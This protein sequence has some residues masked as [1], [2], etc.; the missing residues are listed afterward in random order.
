M[1]QPPRRSRRWTRRCEPSARGEC[2]PAL[3][4][5]S[6]TSRVGLVPGTRPAASSGV[7]QN[8]FRAGRHGVPNR[9]GL[10][11][12][13]P[14]AVGKPV[15]LSR[16]AALRFLPPALH[17]PALLEPPERRV[18]RPL[19]EIEEPVRPFAQF[20]ED[21]EAVLLLLREEGEQAQL[22]R[23][24]LQLRGPL[25]RDFG[26]PGRL[27]SGPRYIGFRS[28]PESSSVVRVRT[29]GCIPPRKAIIVWIREPKKG[30]RGDAYFW[31]LA[32][33]R[34]YKA[35]PMAMPTTASCAARIVNGVRFTPIGRSTN[36]SVEISGS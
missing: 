35:G 24:L 5:P 29:C 32:F 14:T 27:V 34:R 31:R 17:E 12:R 21:L 20:A 22:D 19:L 4:V 23:A 8:A 13:G 2:R 15:V 25:R 10:R 11:Q 18:Q 1:V 28:R 16:H 6:R 36:A 9:E 26:H 33:A 3:P 30:G 7:L